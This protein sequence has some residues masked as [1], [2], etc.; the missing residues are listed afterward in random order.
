MV[1]ASARTYADVAPADSA[2]ADTAHTGETTVFSHRLAV[3]RARGTIARR[4]ARRLLTVLTAATVA[5]GVLPLAAPSASA[6]TYTIKGRVTGLSSTGTVVGVPDAGVWVYDANYDDAG[7]IAYASDGTYTATFSTPGPY[8][9]QAGCWGTMTC[10]SQWGIEW[11]ANEGAFD[12]A[13]PVTAGTTA[14]VADIRLDRRSTIK[15]TVKN[16]AG[17]PITASE[18]SI[19]KST[20]GD[21]VTA[22]P[23]ADGTF[24]LTGVEA[25]PSN[26][27]AEDTSGQNLYENESWNGTASTPDYV[28]WSV[29]AGVTVTGV[30]FVLDPWTGV[31]VKVTDSAGNPL[32]NINWDLLEYRPAEGDWLGQQYGPK[33]T[34][35]DGTVAV[36][37]EVGT[38]YK[39]CVSDTW[40]DNWAPAT[41][42]QDRCWDGATTEATATPFTVT[43]ETRRRDLTIVLPVAGKGLTARE[44]FV[45]GTPTVGSTLTVDPG[46]WA[47]SG[48]TLTYEWMKPNGA[49]TGFV[50][51]PGATGRTF[52][53]T[54]DLLGTY[55]FARV[56]GTLSGYRSAQYYANG[57]EIRSTAPTLASPLT[58]TGSG[59]AGTSLNASHGAISPAGDWSPSY[60]WVVGGVPQDTMWGGLSPLALTSAMVGQRITLRMSAYLDGATLQVNATGPVVLAGTVSGTTPTVTGTA[61]VGS[62][63]TAATGTWGPTPVTLAYQWYRSGVAISGATATTYALTASDLGKA[64]TVKVTGSRASYASTA[65]TSAATTA[66]A[67]GTLTAPTP[68]ISGTKAVGYTLIAV[69]GTWGPA[70]VTLAYQWYRSGVAISGA[71]ASTYK[72][73][74]TDQTKTMTV[75]VTGTKS[76]YT[77]V[78]HTSAATTAVLGSFT[79]PTPTLSGTQRVGYTLTANPG[80]WSPA[81]TTMTYQWYRS[82]AAISGATAKTYKLTSTDRGTYVKVRVTG[83]KSGYLTRS[84]YSPQTAAIG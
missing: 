65:K 67:A 19:S 35:A 38:T 16:T 11:Y 70:P 12:S 39:F 48:V 30:N 44:P 6:A 73:T 8:R 9:I 32:Q 81:P 23:A 24:T 22:R 59:V 61:K 27:M 25:G 45:S 76:G 78:A 66:V 31:V 46:T 56:T 64:M 60:T 26:L 43:T 80:T 83:A 41:R 14:T 75:R 57:V 58:I 28:D 7:T 18:I 77:T 54:S 10:A 17:Q 71:T 33:L 79:A 49:G 63:L 74:T 51:I 40:Y 50:A 53:V 55:V 42:Y 2:G 13:T 62:T 15:G 5:L 3:G 47:P 84:V 20:G 52:T 29:P 82:G 69:P 1:T 68:T 34:S 72:L 21:V 4:A 37:T 36:G